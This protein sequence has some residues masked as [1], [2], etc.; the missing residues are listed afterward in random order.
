VLARYLQDPAGTLAALPPRPSGKPYDTSG[1]GVF[2]NF[3]IVAARA[4]LSRDQAEQLLAEWDHPSIAAYKAKTGF[5]DG[6]EWERQVELATKDVRFREVTGQVS[7]SWVDVAS[8]TDCISTHQDDFVPGLI[9]PGQ[10]TV[11]FGP[12]GSKK[13]TVVIELCMAL[14][15]GQKFFNLPTRFTKILYLAAE[16]P[17]T[18]RYRFQAAIKTRNGRKLDADVLGV[19]KLGGGVF[20]LAEPPG[21]AGQPT[22]DH[23]A[24]KIE[25]LGIGLL[26]VDT[27]RKAAPGDENDP[28]HTTHLF[29]NIEDLMQRSGV[30]V[31]LVH[32]SGKNAAMGASGHSTIQASPEYLLEVVPGTGLVDGRDQKV[33]LLHLAR[34]RSAPDGRDIGY[35]TD[36][37]VLLRD[38]PLGVEF[39]LTAP[40]FVRV[41]GEPEGW[42]RAEN[43]SRKVGGGSKVPPAERIKA[44]L[45]AAGNQPMAQKEIVAATGMAKGTVSK[46][47][48]EMCAGDLPLLV[49]RGDRYALRLYLPPGEAPF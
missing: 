6:R 43:V 8:D 17:S 21:R 37:A 5:P 36:R 19:E 30:A 45:Q 15:L 13:T 23:V 24:A 18:V 27:V 25:K 12:T 10:A 38:S 9:A 22:I 7:T 26:V 2:I 48:R 16:S 42:T 3:W 29:R 20:N 49:L 47:V 28:E 46:A 4:G 35:F 44:A 33:S 39:S 11:L 40:V 32:H 41:K 14:A 34:S 31:L 1:S